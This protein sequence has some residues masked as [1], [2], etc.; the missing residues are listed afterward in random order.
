MA[1]V[2]TGTTYVQVTVTSYTATASTAGA[3]VLTS[4]A[5]ITLTV[6]AGS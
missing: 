1:T 2:P 4:G 6:P 5:Q 3:T